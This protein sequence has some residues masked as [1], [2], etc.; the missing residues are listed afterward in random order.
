MRYTPAGEDPVGAIDSDRRVVPSLPVRGP[1]R[2]RVGAA[3]LAVLLLGSGASA[4][5]A[6]ASDNGT[7]GG[8]VAAAGDMAPP[9]GPH[10]IGVRDLWAME[11]VSD[12]Q[13]SS[14]GQWVAYV[15]RRD[16]VQA[17]TTTSSVWLVAAAGGAPRRLTSALARDTNPRW[18]P[19][20]RR[21]AFL[22][23][24][25][26][27]T[28]IWVLDLD[29]GEPQA[30]TDLPV[31]VE[32]F[33]WSPRGTHLA[34]AAA[35]FPDCPTLDCTAERAAA[36]E[37]SGV[38]R[39]DRLLARHWDAW[40]S[41]R[42]RHLLVVPAAGG[43][44]V[45]L[46]PGADLDAPPPPFGG[47][48]SYAWSPDGRSIVF[49]GR[50]RTADAAWTTDLDVYVAAADGTGFRC[51]TAANLANDE[52]PVWSPDG[53]TIAYLAMMRPGYEADRRRIVLYDV[54][55][56]TRRVLTESWDRSPDEIVWS[57]SGRRLY[58]SVQDRACRRLYRI[59]AESGAEHA[60]PHPGSATSVRVQRGARGDRLVFLGES[61]QQPPDVWGCEPDGR[62]LARLT[63]TNAGVL[64]LARTSTPET[65]W[66]EGAGGARVHA[67]LHPPVDR[68][69][70]DQAPLLLLVHGGPQGSWDDRFHWRWNP[71]VFAGAGYAVL[72][73]DPHGSTGYG[74]A[75]T[76]AVTGD[77]GGQ[78]YEDLMKCVDHVAA[79]VS[80]VDSTRLA[81][82]GGSYGGY[83]IAW[84]A[85]H[86]GRFRCLVSHAGLYDLASFWGTTD[87]Q[88][89]PEWEFLGT[90]WE[91]PEAYAR[92][93]P[94]SHVGTWKTPTL[95][96]L[97][98]RDLRV[99]DGQGLE[100]FA[101]L[102]RRGVPSELLVF[103]EENHWVLEPRNSILWYDAVLAWLDRWLRAAAPARG[104]TAA[105]APIRTDR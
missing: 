91:N 105:S 32:S 95:V 48:E 44:P 98:G 28:Q 47:A 38:R 81:A 93:S 50:E 103:P 46:L 83:M 15:R 51:I 63:D 10:P 37:K 69:D 97:G 58:A 55:S 82:A 99:P 36:S 86:T 43:T 35:V 100:M 29:A 41:G 79:R 101:A 76:D 3:C 20:G 34:L 39:Y 87:E 6:A 52:H 53:R 40:D 4:G 88:W 92:W 84:M 90:P 31:G 72:A 14:D 11:R 16:D 60:I 85:G 17:A 96:S 94:S 74:Q 22:S 5:A 73:P 71:Q 77:W 30:L 13:P 7:V 19:D 9:P 89:F 8:S 18:A 33:A 104:A 12:P 80:W 23:N 66:V 49:A 70:G 56:G 42:R 45:D 57:A 78:P 64:A 1:R 102:Q 61:L 26:G 75:F 27:S 54:A 21:L 68:R 24:R 62:G 65:L 59:D 2:S 67:W 25:G